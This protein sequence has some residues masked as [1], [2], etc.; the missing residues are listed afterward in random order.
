MATPH[1]AIIFD[2]GQ[3]TQGLACLLRLDVRQVLAR[4][5]TR[6]AARDVPLLWGFQPVR[7]MSSKELIAHEIVVN[8]TT[9]RSIAVTLA[10]G[11]AHGPLRLSSYC[12]VS[13]TRP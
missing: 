9:G 10:V 7:V 1:K 8:P 6:R 13:V 11:N 4:T 12:F 3:L 2:S 5:A